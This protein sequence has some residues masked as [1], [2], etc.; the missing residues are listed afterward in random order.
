MSR[1]FP[2][3]AHTSA[4]SFEEA[5][6]LSGGGSIAGY[7]LVYETYGRL[8]GHASN[9]VLVCPALNAAHRVTG[10][11]AD[12]VDGWWSSMVGP[13]KPIDTN[14]FFVI[15]ICNLGSCFGS[16]GPTSPHPADG[17]PYG[18]RFPELTVEDWVDA[19]AR[20]LDRLGIA[21]LAAVVGGSL[22]GMQALCWATRHPHRVRECIAIA[23]CARLSAQ[24]IGFNEVARRAIQSDPAFHGG[25]YLRQGT[26]PRDGLAVARMLGRLTYVTA[27]TLERRHGRQRVEGLVDASGQAPFEVARTLRQRADDFCEYYDANTYLLITRALD[28]FDLTDVDGDLARGLAPASARF[29]LV[30]FTS[31]WRFPSSRTRELADALRQNGQQFEWHDIDAPNGHDA[32]LQRDPAYHRVVREC[33]ERIWRA[34]DAGVA[35][36][37]GAGADWDV[38]IALCPFERDD[39][40]LQV[41]T[42][43]GVADLE[44]PGE[45]LDLLIE[46]DARAL[47]PAQLSAT[48]QA[49]WGES[50]FAEFVDDLVRQGIVTLHAADAARPAI[51]YFQDSVGSDR[52]IARAWLRWPDGECSE[53]WGR[54]A[55]AAV[56]A[57]RALGEA[58]ERH[59][60]SSPP[61][62]HLARGRDVPDREPDRAFIAHTDA[63]YQEPGFP[64]R[65]FSLDDER[66]WLRTTCLASGAPRWMPADAVHPAAA[67]EPALRA[68]RCAAGTSSGF[69]CAPSLDAAIDHA[70]H[71][72]V[73]RDAFMRHW[74]AQRGGIG[75][76]RDGLPDSAV[77]L[78]RELE[79]AG[80]DVHLQCLTRGIAPVWMAF[81][82]HERL[83]FTCTGAASAS[84][85][86]DALDRALAEAHATAMARVA[87]PDLDEP[88]VDPAAADGPAD[89]ARLYAHR[90][91]FQRADALR[92]CERAD[93]FD[94]VLAQCD[95]TVSPR[96]LLAARG[97][98]ASLI[99]FSE[100]ARAFDAD[101]TALRTV[102]V[103]VPDL[104]PLTFGARLLP[105]S[106]GSAERGAYF[107]HPFA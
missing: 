102:R 11:D 47:S 32:F 35:G 22:G 41:M 56:A 82:Q 61:A 42:A 96:V 46:G 105:L 75:L 78:V 74:L 79:D 57:G 48:A 85:G 84:D 73:E 29:L 59:A 103:I 23:T 67:L 8:D 87:V 52:A 1:A 62:G 25:D 69:A 37:V 45:W 14:R 99:D 50:A 4:A 94:R 6:A 18:S 33:F 54:G 91:Y 106:F 43:A 81:V 3:S 55:S 93:R 26:A 19:Q 5:L 13:G 70:L 9:A 40:G 20:L 10:L 38:S 44:A 17:L 31:D 86:A 71:E 27:E 95:P 66:R 107:P 16:T 36:D 65:P 80:C 97:S 92:H 89:H 2:A 98:G 72:L 77:S 60:F 64:L 21:K 100:R 39:V 24:N 104:M 51:E 83:G 88:T 101:G 15:G 7:E 30:S 12:G 28:L 63:Q 58:V 49:R 68:L 76:R 90:R 34:I 53:G